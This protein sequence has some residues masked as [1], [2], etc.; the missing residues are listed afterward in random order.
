MAN[1]NEEI[2]NVYENIRDWEWEHGEDFLDSSGFDI[3]EIPFMT[4]CFLEGHVPINEYMKWEYDRRAGNLKAIDPNYF[5]YND[6][7]EY[8]ASYAIVHSDA[9]NEEDQEK[10]YMI[11]AEYIVTVKPNLERFNQFM[12]EF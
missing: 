9:W 12:G 11:L 2:R 8:G 4:W 3:N 6:E 5:L 7:G 1:I 10:A